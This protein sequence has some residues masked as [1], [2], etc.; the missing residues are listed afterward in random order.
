MDTEFLHPGK[1][2]ALA[3]GKYQNFTI[4][5]KRKASGGWTFGGQP[6]AADT[7]TVNGTVF[8]FVASGA[9]GNQINIGVDL[10]TT[11]DN[12]V[13]VLQASVVAGVAV[14]SYSNVGGTKLR[15]IYDA[16]GDAGNAFTVA[17]AGTNIT[18]IN[19]TL[20]GG[21]DQDTLD[22]TAET[23]ALVTSNAVEAST[24]MEYDLPSGAEGQEVTL[25]FKT[26]GTSS[27]ALVNGVFTG[28][29]VLT[30]DTVGKF[31]KLKFLDGTWRV[32]ANTGSIA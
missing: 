16:Y 10:T 21:A 13:T 15:V 12:A 14:A 23:Y 9:T 7:I 5:G 26:K 32:I 17:K 22:L 29:T 6:S 2:A 8:T 24:N 27:N 19:A 25:Y 11:I 4:G 18:V 1:V 28:G 30:L 31:A 3:A 20:Q